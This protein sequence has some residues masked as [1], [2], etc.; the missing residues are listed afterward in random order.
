MKI[1]ISCTDDHSLKSEVVVYSLSFDVSTQIFYMPCPMGDDWLQRLNCPLKAS[2]IAIHF[3][4]GA[5]S[6][7]FASRNDAE[8]FALWL[9]DAEAAAQHGYATMRG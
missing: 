9:Q 1:S 2:P 7:A 6:V 5:A 4:M 8:S 3:Q